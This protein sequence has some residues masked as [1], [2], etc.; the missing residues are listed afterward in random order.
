MRLAKKP[1]SV[2]DTLKQ[3]KIKQQQK[4]QATEIT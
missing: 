4:K 1:E 2:T 3:S